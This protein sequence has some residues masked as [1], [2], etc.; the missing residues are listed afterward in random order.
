MGTDPRETPIY[1]DYNATT[2]VLPQVRDA[3]LPFLDTHFGNP[4]SDHPY[5]RAAA[6]GV[7]RARQQVADLLGCAA[8][9]VVF[10]SGGS[11]SDNWALIGRVW[12]TGSDRAHVVTTI[13]E[14]P[15]VLN[16][17]RFLE[18]RGVAVTYLPVDGTGQVDPD[19]VRRA[20]RPETVVVSVMHA[21]NEVG[22]L[23]PIGEIAAICREAGVPL[24]T[25]AAQSVG[26]VATRV[27]DLGVDML[28]IAGH[29]LYAP[30]GIGA[31]YVRR[32]TAL[33]PLIHGAGHEGGRR[34]GTE[35]V[36]WMVALGAAAALAGATLEGEA[37][38]QRALR[39]RLHR[40]LEEKAGGVTLNGHPTARL[41]NTLNVR[42]AGID[43]NALLAAVPEVAASTGSACHAGETE[44]SAVLLA[45][46]IP[47]EEAV[48]AVRLSLGRLTTEDEVDR[49]AEALAAGVARL[50]A[51]G[52]M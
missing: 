46:G 25:D 13:V 50:R 39:D 19:D 35:N 29:K 9:E 20:L 6:K 42:F 32:G 47:P 38:R 15:A 34:A 11:E 51:R 52:G 17:C 4:S 23:Q 5:G 27:D 26:K 48:G 45:M 36:P 31:L 16:T 1:L 28:T 30:K 24:H 44:P 21:N 2:P 22:T 12:A 3:L 14:H 18:R 8:D 10:T 33:E 7:Q 43:G 37:A 40:L 49:A 41:P